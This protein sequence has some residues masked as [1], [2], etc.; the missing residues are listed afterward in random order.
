MDTALAHSR[1]RRRMAGLSSA[2]LVAAV[3]IA[4][5]EREAEQQRGA[6]AA[7]SQ[8]SANVERGR[9]IYE[10]TCAQ[11]HAMWPVTGFSAQ[12]WNDILPRMVVLSELS[13]EEA[14]SVRAYIDAEL[15]AAAS[16]SIGQ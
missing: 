5:S 15:A 16:S 13:D 12:A 10:N 2:I 6:S 8:V 9:Q 1:A 14:A 4:C 3:V 7:A 11:C